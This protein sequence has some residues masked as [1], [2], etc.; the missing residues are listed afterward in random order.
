[1]KQHIEIAEKLAEAMKREGHDLDGADR[2]IIRNAISGSMAAQ[3]RRE[4]YARSAAVSFNWIKPKT[5]RGK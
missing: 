5:P 2:L 1:M 4:S 3:R